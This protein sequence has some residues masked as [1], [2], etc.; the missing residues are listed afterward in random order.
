MTSIN[1]LWV[2]GMMIAGGVV[3]GFAQLPNTQDKPLSPVVLPGSGLKQHDFFYAGETEPEQM[4][5][6]RKGKIVWSYT[7]S[8]DGEISDAVLLPNGNILFARQFGITEIAPDKTVVWNFNSPPNT[9]IHTVQPIGA[10]SVLFVQNGDPAKLIVM[11]KR[12]QAMEHEFTLPT[13]NAEVVHQ[14]FLAASQTGGHDLDVWRLRYIHAQFRRARLTDTKTVLVADMSVGKV[15]EF[16]LDGKELWSLDAPY[17]WSAEPLKNGNVL[18]VDGDYRDRS[19]RE[20]NRKGETV[21]EFGS[22]DAPDYQL[23]QMQTA[24]RLKNGNTLINNW[25]NQ[26][27]GKGNEMTGTGKV[28]PSNAPVQAIEVTPD[29]KIVWAL[30]AW[31]PPEDLGPSTTIQIL[32][33]Q[34]R[35]KVPS[36]SH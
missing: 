12:T 29:K 1:G 31:A 4:Y 35:P 26:W 6:I 25:F 20:V 28:D 2:I 23:L 10:D 22:P 15:I 9:E 5:I 18:V 7:K 24:T 36:L 27:A 33:E 32:S 34:E 14:Q 8:G 17:V 19:V 11:N 21:W 30:R 13:K 16:D 3:S